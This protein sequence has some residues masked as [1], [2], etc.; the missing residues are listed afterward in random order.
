MGIAFLFVK[1]KQ[2]EKRYFYV[3]M[4][5]KTKNTIAKKM[6]M[7]YNKRKVWSKKPIKQDLFIKN[8]VTC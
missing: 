8:W 7:L 5:K 1:N 3:S 6:G 4:Y 2:K